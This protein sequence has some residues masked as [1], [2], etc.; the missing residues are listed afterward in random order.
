MSVEFI[1]M[2]QSQKQLEIYL[3]FGFVVDFDYVCDFV[4]VYEMVGFDWIFVLYYLIGLLVMLMI[5][6]VVVVIECIYFMFVYC[7]GFI[8]LMFVVWQIVMFDQFSCG[9]F[10]VYFIFGG[11]DSEQQ[12]DGD[13][14]DYDVCYVCIDEYLGI[15][16]WIWMEMQLFDYDGVYY[17]FKQG[18]LEVKLFQQLYVL[19][20]FGGVLE[21]VFVVVG[22]YVDVYVLWGELFDQVCDLMICVCVEV[23][24]YGCQVC[25]FV[26]FC[27]IFVVIEDEVWVCVYCIFDEMC[28]LC[29]VVGFGVG[30]LQQSEGV[31]CL[32]VVVECGLCVDKWLWIEIVK[33]IGVCLNLMVFVGMFE[34][35]VDVLFDYYDFGVMIFLICGFDLLE[36]VIDYG[37][38][39]ILCVCNVVVECDV[40]CC[41]V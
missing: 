3:V 7:L 14:F 2:I 16:W 36:D 19:I 20:Y 31:C 15:L 28:W 1:G 23:V 34:Q 9:W 25:F 12:C 22:K 39:L 13:F 26:L 21:V 29:E 6:F 32:F 18:F 8:V 4:C 35:V 38:E 24:K 41:V 5:V 30:G 40:V 33:F 27:L 10:V 37:C 11:L 17:W